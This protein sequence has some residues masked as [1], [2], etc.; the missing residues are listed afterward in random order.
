MSSPAEAVYVLAKN[1]GLD[2]EEE[3]DLDRWYAGKIYY[4]IEGLRVRLV[5]DIGYCN[6][7]VNFS[8]NNSFIEKCKSWRFEDDVD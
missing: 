3:E 2:I 8:T 6:D 1:Y 4:K 5:K 7:C